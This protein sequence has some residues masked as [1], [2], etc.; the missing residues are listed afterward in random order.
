MVHWDWPVV[1]IA[2]IIALVALGIVGI[3]LRWIVRVVRPVKRPD[4][5]ELAAEVLG[6]RGSRSA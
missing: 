2:G 4:V 6:K 3:G 1:A 5:A